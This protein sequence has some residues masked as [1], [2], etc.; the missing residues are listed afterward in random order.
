MSMIYRI[1]FLHV[2]EEGIDIPLL[3]ITD[4]SI[5]T[6]YQVDRFFN[7]DDFKHF[8]DK[9]EIKE[10]NVYGYPIKVLTIGGSIVHPRMESEPVRME[11]SVHHIYS[12]TGE[13]NML[14]IMHHNEN[15][16]EQ[17]AKTIST[18]TV[19]EEK[20]SDSEMSTGD[21]GAAK[22]DKKG[23]NTISSTD[24]IM[25][26]ESLF[27]VVGF[28]SADNN[29]EYILC[30]YEKYLP[31]EIVKEVYGDSLGKAI[32]QGYKYNNS[33][34]SYTVQKFRTLLDD[35]KI[36]NE[37]ISRL[38][39]DKVI[40]KLLL[41]SIKTI[42]DLD[43]FIKGGYIL[44]NNPTNLPTL[45][46]TYKDNQVIFSSGKELDKNAITHMIV[47]GLKNYNAT[48][49]KLNS[50][51]ERVYD[52]S[53]KLLCLEYLIFNNANIPVG[54]IAQNCYITPETSMYFIP[55]ETSL[56]EIV[57]NIQYTERLP[58]VDNKINYSKLFGKVENIIVDALPTNLSD[59]ESIA[60]L[61]SILQSVPRFK[62]V[63]LLPELMTFKDTLSEEL[64]H[65][66]V[67]C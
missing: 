18:N 56:I 59:L 15:L 39:D 65:Y 41:A 2:E 26:L 61:T 3:Y 50:D 30:N 55:I 62:N 63:E 4:K 64:S 11:A 66:G 9:A 67:D 57:S 54:V 19:V 33:L 14:D 12:S 60:E 43:K 51:Y 53:D 38:S 6:N 24:D 45:E 5:E 34:L 44:L 49:D 28:D 20:P 46:A 35:S 25:T 21:I 10:Y 31:I 8:K 29:Q 22:E 47:N 40:V 27:G 13:C 48:L 52:F 32:E 58:I 23:D 17:I 1:A 36:I 37:V 16:Y 7:L 42:N